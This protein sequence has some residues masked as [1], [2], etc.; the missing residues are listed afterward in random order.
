MMS[1]TLLNHIQ[2]KTGSR[3]AQF[4]R[5]TGTDYTLMMAIDAANTHIRR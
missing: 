1:Y 5:D 4:V 2:G 3:W